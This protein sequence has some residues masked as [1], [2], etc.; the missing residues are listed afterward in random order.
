MVAGCVLVDILC[1]IA[2]GFSE[3]VSLCQVFIAHRNEHHEVALFRIDSAEDFARLLEFDVPAHPVT[4]VHRTFAVAED[5]LCLVGLLQAGGEV[6][7]ER[8]VD[9]VGNL[10]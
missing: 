5:L 2:E 4:A 3:Q 1:V 10:V 8:A 7:P 9:E 6:N